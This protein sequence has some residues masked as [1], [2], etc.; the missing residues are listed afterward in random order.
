M[1][2]NARVFKVIGE[3]KPDN[4]YFSEIST[5]LLC[6]CC[7][8]VNLCLQVYMRMG[9]TVSD[10]DKHFAGPAFLAW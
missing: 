4:T 6:K 9:F 2:H 3:G 7:K 8:H 1:Q 5:N 10:L